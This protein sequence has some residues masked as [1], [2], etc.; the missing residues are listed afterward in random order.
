M[1]LEKQNFYFDVFKGSLTAYWQ[2]V[3]SLL[4]ALWQV[5]I[6]YWP[7]IPQITSDLF[8]RLSKIVN[9]PKTIKKEKNNHENNGFLAIKK[10]P[11][12]KVISSKEWI[13]LESPILRFGREKSHVRY[14]FTKFSHRIYYILFNY[15]M[16]L[17][18]FF[19]FFFEEWI[20]MR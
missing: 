2:L 18:F 8:F 9:N 20:V 3:D 7:S 13:V 6:I 5:S 11:Q 4:T 15:L 16:E 1:N 12:R 10:N 19:Y 14:D 17:C